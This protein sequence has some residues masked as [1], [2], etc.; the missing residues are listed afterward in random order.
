MQFFC[1]IVFMVKIPDKMPR[2]VKKKKVIFFFC[3]RLLIFDV[4][5]SNNAYK[6]IKNPGAFTLKLRLVLR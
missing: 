4:F 3:S 1:S 2:F 6:N 5:V